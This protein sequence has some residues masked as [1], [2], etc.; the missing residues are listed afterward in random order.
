MKEATKGCWRYLVIANGQVALSLLVAAMQM[1]YLRFDLSTRIQSNINLLPLRVVY[2]P[3]A[4]SLLICR[5]LKI[6]IFQ[7]KSSTCLSQFQQIY[8]GWIYPLQSLEK[9]KGV[10]LHNTRS[11]DRSTRMKVLACKKISL[12]QLLFDL[13]CIVPFYSLLWNAYI[14]YKTSC[15][16]LEREIFFVLAILVKK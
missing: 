4:L 3:N 5:F 9:N 10:L 6:L 1:V 2:K 14:L 12:V 8:S 16:S 13:I 7:R 11:N 15:I